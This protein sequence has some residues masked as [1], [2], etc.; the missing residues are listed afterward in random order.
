V[1]NTGPDNAEPGRRVNIDV[2]FVLIYY[3]SEILDSYRRTKQ[4]S[5]GRLQHYTAPA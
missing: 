5:L 1:E 3:V 2:Y 4:T